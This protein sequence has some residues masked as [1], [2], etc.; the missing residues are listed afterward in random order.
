MAVEHMVIQ[1]D[2]REYLI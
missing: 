2:Q 1:A